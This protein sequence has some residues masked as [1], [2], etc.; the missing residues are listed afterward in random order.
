MTTQRGS[1]LAWFAWLT[2]A[3][4]FFY[5]WVLRVSPSVIVDDLMA[6]FA[7]GGAIVGHLSAMYFYGYAGMQVPVGLLLDRFGPRRLITLAALVC[8]AGGVGF[9]LSPSILTLSISR[10]VVGM[11]AA[12]SLMGAVYVAHQWLPARR[13]AMLSGIAMMFGMAGGVLGQ[14]P[15]SLAVDAVG[16]RTALLWIAVAGASLAVVA[17]LTVRDKP[18]SENPS[19]GGVLSGLLEVAQERQTWFNAIAGLGLSGP[20]LGFGALWAVPYLQLLIDVPGAQAAGI[21]STVFVGM[22]LGAPFF[23]WLSDSLNRRKGPLMVGIALTASALLYLMFAPVHGP[24]D[25]GAACF[26]IGFGVSAQIV[27]FAFARA[28]NPAYR[29]A[30]AIGLLNALV[31]GAGALFQPTIG[32]L[33]DRAWDGTTADGIRI[34]HL[35]DYQEAFLALLVGLAIAMIAASQL[36]EPAGTP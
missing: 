33:L 5:A 35:A 25:A 8:A 16:W 1:L 10:L 13:F 11:G 27:C 7:V 30:T 14:A 4:F 3:V 31:T 23:G 2:A 15:V 20:L 6:E 34:Y 17:W 12:F 26:V 29:A 28:H 32:W 18:S 9:A 24:I 22:G 19:A 21:T 36:R